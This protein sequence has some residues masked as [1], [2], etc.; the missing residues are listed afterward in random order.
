MM[1]RI[2]LAA[3]SFQGALWLLM[4]PLV[5][6]FA[7]VPVIC[8]VMI[9][10]VGAANA[11]HGIVSRL[12]TF[13]PVFVVCWQMGFLREQL[14]QEGNEVLFVYQHSGRSRLGEVLTLAGLYSLCIL[15]VIAV[16]E[17]AFGLRLLHI[18]PLRLGIQCLF[19]SALFYAVAC[20]VRNIGMALIVVLVYYFVAAFYSVGTSL[21]SI[22]IF[23]F[24]KSMAI[25]GIN[26]VDLIV[27]VFSAVLLYVGYR[28]I[29]G[30]LK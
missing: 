13:I 11:I 6:V 27:A 28:A 19:F 24:M 20:M 5:V 14:E 10:E 30:E 8:M 3:L 26:A 25:P 2:Q 22:S 16:M 29:E 21:E 12:Q 23:Q 17:I 9:A 4:L 1:K 7:L 15:G 18:M